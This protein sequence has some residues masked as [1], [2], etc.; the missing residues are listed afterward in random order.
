MFRII[1]DFARNIAI[2]NCVITATISIAVFEF[3]LLF[4]VKPY[5][6]QKNVNYD[7]LAWL[8]VV[9]GY[10]ITIACQIMMYAG[11]ID[12]KV[13]NEDVENS[14]VKDVPYVVCF[15]HSSNLDSFIITAAFPGRT[16]FI[17]KEALKKIP[18]FGW[19]YQKTNMII[20]NRASHEDAMKTMKKA[21][22]FMMENK[23]NI[24]IAPEGTRRRKMTDPD[25][26]G[27]GLQEFKKGAFYLAKNTET[28]IAP[29]VLYG[30]KRICP[31]NE[32]LIKQGTI[33]V[34]ICRPI[35]KK[36]IQDLSVDELTEYTRNYISEEMAKKN[37]I[38]TDE[39]IRTKIYSLKMILSFIGIYSLNG[40]CAWVFIGMMKTYFFKLLF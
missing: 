30:G 13:I 14:V 7:T 23:V 38:V 22:T 21:E 25:D 1:W 39:L 16:Y 32:A 26:L 34:H 20:L 11:F 4:T 9:R 37:G 33:V 36:I 27:G 12:L 24:A 2:L 15:T 19:V 29:V 6:K 18:V 10:M 35:D 28:Y 31:P 8:H 5:Y 3:I 17:A 40:Y